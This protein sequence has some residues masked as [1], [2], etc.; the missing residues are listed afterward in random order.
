MIAGIAEL[1]GIAK[2]VATAAVGTR[3]VDSSDRPHAFSRIAVALFVVLFAAALTLPAVAAE[4]QNESPKIYVEYNGGYSWIPNQRLTGADP[5]GANLDGRADSGSGFNVGGAIGAK[6]KKYFRAELAINYRQSEVRRARVQRERRMASGQISLLAILVNG[7]VD[8][9]FGQPVIPY[10]GIGIGYGSAEI[11]A[12]NRA[13]ALQLRIEG[14]DSVF[15]WNV[16]TGIS[17]PVNEVLDLS[18]G[19][20][21]I[22]TENTR[23]NSSIRNLGARRLDSEFDAHEAVMGLRFSF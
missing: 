8:L 23:I 21:Y 5:S 20:R 16:M 12:K 6:F 1:A 2:A 22:A 13:D 7:Y 4:P 18:L 11:D 14:R 3:S 9:D 15:A 19:Y 17:V 10:V